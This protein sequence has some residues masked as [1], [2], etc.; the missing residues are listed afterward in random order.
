MSKNHVSILSIIKQV[1]QTSQYKF[2]YNDNTVDVN[3]EVDV[4]VRNASI[5]TLLNDVFKSTDI[6]YSIEG[7]KVLLVT[8]ERNKSNVN[9][10][11]KNVSGLVLDEKNE[12]IIG[13]SVLVKGTTNG[14]ITDVDGKFILSEVPN[15]STLVISYVGYVTKNIAVGSKS[16][17]KIDLLE[18]TK[19]LDE[20]VVVGYGTQRKVNLTGSVSTVKGEDMVK[21]S[22][23]QTSQALQ[24]LA[25]GLYVQQDAGNPGATVNLNIRGIGTLGNSSPLVLIDGVDGDLNNVN[26]ND[27][28]SISVLKDAAS[29]SIYGSRA[30]NGVILI[31]TKRGNS[32]KVDFDVRMNIGVQHQTFTPK[33]LGGLDYMQLR[34]EAYT[35]EGKTPMYTED[36]ISKYKANRGSEEYPDTDWGKEVFSEP[37]LQQSY[38]ITATGGSKK[39]KLLLSANY[40]SQQ[41][42]MKNTGFDR[43]GLRINSDLTPTEK[44]NVSIDL[45]ANYTQRWE[46]GSGFGETL[47]QTYRT[48][49]MY[50]AYYDGGSRF[51]EGYIGT[52]PAA[53]ASEDAGRNE[54]KCADITALGKLSYEPL[55]GLKATFIFSPHFMYYNDKNY[56]K[57]MTL[58]SL[59]KSVAFYNPS[60]TKL[61]RLNTDDMNLNT[62]LYL[63]YTK[64]IKDHNIALLAGYEQIYYK[65]DWLSGYRDNFILSDYSEL[66]A[67]DVTNQQAK[68]TGYEWALQSY[69]G[70]INYDYKGKYLLEANIRRDGSSRFSKNNRWGTF[71][72][73]SGGWRISEENFMKNIQW[74]S[75]LKITGSWGKLGN[76]LIGNYPY[77]SSIVFGTNVVDHELVNSASQTDYSNSSITWEKTTVTNVALDFSLFK[78]TLYG[79]FE[80]YNKVTSDILLNL[81]IPKTM[82][83]NASAQNAGKVRNRGWDLTLGYRNTINGFHYSVLGMLSDVRN[84]VISLKGGGP[85]YDTG[86]ITQEGSPIGSLFGYVCEGIFQSNE[87]VSSHAKQSGIVE[88]GDLKYKDLNGD[89]TIDAKDR[90]IIGNPIPRYTYS[91]NFSA[92][93]KNF[94]FSFLFQGIGKRDV[95]LTYDA[96]LPFY[97]GGKVQNIHLDRWTPENKNASFPRLTTTYT[98]NQEISSFFVKSGAFLRLKNIQ[99]GYNLSKKVLDK[100]N[101]KNCRLYVSADNL[102]ELNNFWEGWDPEV[103]SVTS[104]NSYPQ[105][106]IISCGLNVKF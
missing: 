100:L 77:I 64:K 98:N 35:N 60:L 34:N 44:I 14:T 97:N 49:P 40:I 81:P 42:N 66:N 83:L 73:F 56:I 80:Y 53:I 11:R 72:S 69:F 93:Y 65:D 10:G 90:A 18:D 62:K 104:G 36:Y 99:F 24:G 52:N 58:Y 46:P 37:G 32:D 19:T 57:K 43:Y 87:E 74:L 94:D 68:G 3:N 20:V 76:Q 17:L 79:T 41:G 82:G 4:N 91:L 84:K 106:R 47:Y 15:N 30:A 31:T 12:P 1:E 59:D 33:Y 6:S 71:P 13:A 51:A 89:N 54:Y 50:A 25:P 102:F 103:S 16:S 63:N 55:S 38:G 96:I 23:S 9:K 101:I 95:L 8:K 39:A 67:G 29:A 105:T 48:A 70:R 5:G 2:F 92:E 7:K 21:R 27:I 86:T 85:F 78:N 45:N 26:S 61:T 28:E 88:A 22:V 75:N